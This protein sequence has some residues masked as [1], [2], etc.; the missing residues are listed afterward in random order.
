M[1]I[2]PAQRALN[3]Y[4]TATFTVAGKEIIV[5]GKKGTLQYLGLT[6]DAV[7]V[8]ASSSGEDR[9]FTR[10]AHRRPRW[11]GD[12]VGI[13]VRETTGTVYEYASSSGN[14]KP[15]RPFKFKALT[16]TQN[17]PKGQKV[18]GT[19]SLQGPWGHFIEHMLGDRPPHSVR[20]WSTDGAKM[21]EAVLNAADFAALD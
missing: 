5:G 12:S 7:S 9:T 15:G 6:P 4:A 17:H 19:L 14:A 11:L 3:A 21:E 13:A 10:A 1:A 8:D 16:D 18:T 20:F 2:T